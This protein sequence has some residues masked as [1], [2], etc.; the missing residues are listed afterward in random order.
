ME[1]GF[2]YGIITLNINNIAT[3]NNVYLSKRDQ[4]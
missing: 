2:Q 3:F 1:K 4:T